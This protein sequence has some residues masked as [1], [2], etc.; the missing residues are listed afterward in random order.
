M[1][2]KLAFR[3]ILV[4]GVTALLTIGIYSAFSTRA[5]SER[6]QAEVER[7]ASQLSETVKRSTRYSMLLNQREHV[8]KII[9]DVGEDSTIHEVRVLNKEGKIIFS[10]RPENIGQMVDKKA[11]SCFACHAADRPL[12]RLSVLQRTRVFRIHPDSARILGVIA[13]IYNER[14]CWEADCHAHSQSLSV[15]GVLDITTSLAQ[16]DQQIE[17]S[18][19]ANAIFAVFAVF[20]LSIIIGYFVRRWVGNPVN[21][22]IAATREVGGGN[23]AYRIPHLG[24]DDL[25]MLARAFNT[26]TEKLSE[27]RL[28]LFQ[29]DKMASLGRLA[30]GVA[31]EL[32]NPL[33]GVLTYSSFLLNRAGD[34]HEARADLEVIV[35]EATRSREIVKSLLDFARQSVPKKSTAN[36]NE[37]IGRS[38]AVLQKQLEVRGV[39]VAKCLDEHLPPVRVDAN[40][41]QQVIVNLLV[42]AAD[43]IGEEGGS[44]TVTT[45]S[46]TLPPQGVAHI[47]RAFCPKGHDLMDNEVKV[48]GLAS[49]KVAA[50]WGGGKGDVLLD[51]VYGKTRHRY[52]VGL[53]EGH[54]AEFVCPRCGAS[55]LEPGLRCPV[56]SAPGYA[57]LV[58]PRGT[59]QGCTRRGCPWQYWE[60]VE[61]EGYREYIEMTVA[62]TGSGISPDDMNKVFEPFYTTKEQRGTGLGL[63]V[64]WGIVDNHNGTIGVRSE[65]GKGTIFTIR[66]PID[67][68]R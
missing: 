31:H 26:M 41:I 51:P 44:V 28:Q 2:R 10:S 61:A 50:R 36:L 66:L 59:I 12:E 8:H 20:A 23:L 27:A 15:L 7:H 39:Q 21:N 17:G 29:S 22:L 46:V 14:A 34:N 30:A 60:A 5:Q 19:K 56:C 57:L 24:E 67:H 40:Q 68:E 6:M 43:A 38:V 3:L 4:V 18:E 16:V 45:S 42:N 54:A 53:A 9:N 1:Y 11:E 63:A 48:D 35:R 65:L 62:D 55:L 32:N 58:P 49:V 47:K 25:G 37:I 13:P 33:T 52:E 64:V